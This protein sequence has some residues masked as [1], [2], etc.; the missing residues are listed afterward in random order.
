MLKD[1]IR[2]LKLVTREAPGLR[3]LTDPQ[4][5]QSIRDTLRNRKEQLLRASYLAVARDD[6]RV[7]NYLARQVL[8]SNGKLPA[9]AK[10]TLLASRSLHKIKFSQLNLFHPGEHISAFTAVLLSQSFLDSSALR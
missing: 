1:S 3:G 4:V 6:A 9:A 5:Q 8:E 2:I 10:T 7:T